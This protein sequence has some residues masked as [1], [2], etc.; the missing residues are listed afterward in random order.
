MR[1]DN[2][3]QFLI[4]SFREYCVEL[5]HQKQKMIILW[6]QCKTHAT[7]FPFRWIQDPNFAEIYTVRKKLLI[8]T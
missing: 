6:N 3:I 4:L 1:L 5:S 7:P 2:K 8:I